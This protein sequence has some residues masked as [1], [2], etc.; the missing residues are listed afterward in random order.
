MGGTVGA[1]IGQI[2]GVASALGQ[3]AATPVTLDSASSALGAIG[4]AVGGRVGEAASRV[5]SAVSAVRS[6][7]GGDVSSAL[8]GVGAAIGGR[9]G[10]VVAQASTA[11]SAVRNAMSGGTM[12]IS[13]AI[14]GVASA[15][16]GKVKCSGLDFCEIR[17]A[18]TPLRQA[19]AAVAR[20]QTGVAAA[21][22]F[23]SGNI[24]GGIS[25]IA[26]A[27]GGKVGA[28][29]GKVVETVQ[30]VKKV[31]SAVKTGMALFKAGGGIGAAMKGGM[32]VRASPFDV[33]LC[34]RFALTVVLCAGDG[35]YGCRTGGAGAHVGQQ[36]F[37]K[38]VRGLH[39]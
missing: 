12:D 28:K 10:A 19:G 17:F 13:S 31:V 18:L 38:Y 1:R 37:S 32:A 11:V 39:V 22:A 26:G 29:I 5:A 9:A 2:S 30:K 24:M 3:L 36:A 33:L 34:V 23:V 35:P 20:V 27:I 6:I 15:I 4:A 8:A 14:S 16:G 25:G 7:Q 21:R